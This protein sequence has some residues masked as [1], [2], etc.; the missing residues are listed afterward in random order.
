VVVYGV[1]SYWWAQNRVK[2][3]AVRWQLGARRRMIAAEDS[4]ISGGVDGGRPWEG[5]HV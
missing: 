2:K 3:S 4:N 5:G 1:L